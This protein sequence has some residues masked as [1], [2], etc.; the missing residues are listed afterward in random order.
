MHQLELARLEMAK[1]EHSAAPVYSVSV[2]WHKEPEPAV[3]AYSATLLE[4][5]LSR[6]RYL[7]AT[8]P[9]DHV[10]ALLSLTHQILAQSQSEE[11]RSVR[12]TAMYIDY[13]KSVARVFQ[14]ATRCILNRDRRLNILTY[15]RGRG[16]SRLKLDL[17]SWVVDW[18]SATDG[19]DYN[20]V[21]FDHSDS[22]LTR[23]EHSDNGTIVLH[24]FHLGR[25]AS[26]GRPM[27]IKHAKETA[28]RLHQRHTRLPIT[29][30]PRLPT[31]VSQ[32]KYRVSIR[33]LT[34][35]S[36]IT[37]TFDVA[38]GWDWTRP[39]ETHPTPGFDLPRTDARRFKV[40]D[41]F[42]QA[43]GWDF[44]VILREEEVVGPA[45]RFR[46]VDLV[47]DRDFLLRI[48]GPQQYPWPELRQ[49]Y[50]GSMARPVGLTKRLVGC[51][52]PGGKQDFVV[53]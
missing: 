1:R 13:S 8:D 35:H 29:S 16:A 42:V 48:L 3:L 39:T 19:A 47:S 4:K 2:S 27:S 43:E 50:D 11:A 49:T 37:P 17:P 36:H 33:T 22:M 45:K 52:P 32:P 46:L 30:Q 5:G 51:V 23:Q 6:S 40:G 9:R 15:R 31:T 24:G 21:Y 10:Y 38:L 44:P 28:H 41:L 20:D 34:L 25:L 7:D 53:C 14:D 18:T 26:I 12:G